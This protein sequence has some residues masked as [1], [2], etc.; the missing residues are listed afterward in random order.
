MRLMNNITTAT[1]RTALIGLIINIE[2]QR[3]DL[4]LFVCGLANNTSSNDR[5][6][7][8]QEKSS[9]PTSCEPIVLP[10]INFHIFIH[11]M[12]LFYVINNKESYEHYVEKY[13][14]I[15]SIN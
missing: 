14:Y 10:Y 15:P 1:L 5:T 9:L 7:L 11:I 8:V 4:E 13:S 6:V 2:V 12:I 3:T